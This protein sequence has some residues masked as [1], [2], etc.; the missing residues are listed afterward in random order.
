MQLVGLAPL[1]LSLLSTTV[2]A[3]SNEEKKGILKVEQLSLYTTPAKAYHFEDAKPTRLE[4]GISALRNHVNPYTAQFQG[5]Y[6]NLQPKIERTVQLGKDGYIFL[7]NPPSGFYPRAGV[8]T[9]A[10]VAGLL[11]AGRGSRARKVIYSC[12]FVAACASLYYPQ[13]TVEIAKVTSSSLYEMSMQSYLA[14]ESLWKKYRSHNQEPSPTQG[15]NK[16]D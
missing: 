7:K 15:S 11:L 14:I 10:G 9:L 12:G 6:K 5:V 1:R 13:A 4:E 3:Q 16:V 8:I 2:L